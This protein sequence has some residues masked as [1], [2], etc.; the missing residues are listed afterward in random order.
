MAHVR[1]RGFA[2]SEIPYAALFLFTFSQRARCAAAIRLRLRLA[3]HKK[4]LGAP[5]NEG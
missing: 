1:R 3:L 2:P 4:P 5:P